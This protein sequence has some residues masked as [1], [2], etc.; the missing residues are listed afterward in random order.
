MSFAI[1]KASG[2]R[3]SE[4]PH[5]ALFLCAKTTLDPSFYRQKP[6]FAGRVSTNGLDDTNPNFKE[7]YCVISV[8]QEEGK[9]TMLF[10]R[11]GKKTS[12]KKHHRTV[13]ALDGNVSFAF[14]T[15]KGHEVELFMS[16]GSDYFVASISTQ[17]RYRV[18]GPFI[19]RP[20]E[21]Q[22]LYSMVNALIRA[23][24]RNIS[25][26][27]EDFVT[28]ES[29][30]AGMRTLLEKVEKGVQKRNVDT[31]KLNT[32]F[33]TV[34][35][36]ISTEVKYLSSYDR[37]QVS[38]RHIDLFLSC[39]ADAEVMIYETRFN[40]LMGKVEAAAS[41]ANKA[42]R[43]IASG[44]QE[45]DFLIAEDSAKVIK[46][47]GLMNMSSFVMSEVEEA[48][49]L[50][51]HEAFY[52]VKEMQK[53]HAFLDFT[54]S[55]E[56][57]NEQKK[58]NDFLSSS[59]QRVTRR[60]L[61]LGTL[62]KNLRGL[63]YF[64]SEQLDRLDE[65]LG[66]ERKRA[67]EINDKVAQAE[68]QMDVIARELRGLNINEPGRK[69]SLRLRVRS[70]L[71][72]F[73]N[74]TGVDKSVVVMM[75]VFNDCVA[76]G[77]PDANS[78]QFTLHEAYSLSGPELFHFDEQA[79]SLKVLH[80]TAGGEEFIELEK[81][82]LVGDS[83]QIVKEAIAEAEK[84]AKA[85]LLSFPLPQREPVRNSPAA[86]LLNKIGVRAPSPLGGSN[87]PP[88]PQGSYRAGSPQRAPSPGVWGMFQG[89]FRSRPPSPSKSDASHIANV[90]LSPAPTVV[91]IRM[92][93]GQ[94]P[95]K[96]GRSYT[97]SMSQPGSVSKL[98]T[99]APSPNQNLGSNVPH[100]Q[101][102]MSTPVPNK[103]SVHRAP[104]PGLRDSNSALG[105]GTPQKATM[106]DSTKAALDRHNLTT[107]RIQTLSS[108]ENRAPTS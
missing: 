77:R 64:S 4:F 52:L 91:P 18:S 16:K 73:S 6:V 80:R 19:I 100:R 17:E 75:Y 106:Y 103:E 105:R 32:L 66:T 49:L 61:L 54:A 94:T 20:M 50:K 51:T 11:A 45:I 1:R 37:F 28:E 59:M 15:L 90:P 93:R 92:D 101:M 31:A 5:P 39:F 24:P 33:R 95:S 89:S 55:L 62:C 60:P 87:R 9:G 3:V 88:S 104:S 107:P 25:K 13:F 57:A 53:N 29:V 26:L 99:R 63:N 10:M 72:N 46:L 36:A 84:Y 35:E 102:M 82:D 81:I 69:C 14:S 86:A 71:G 44:L 76:I 34:E 30:L 41:A 38:M 42:M 40:E 56:L 65:M 23:G 7:Y 12:S 108:R 70:N 78:D 58:L 96:T 2:P 43:T 74:D 67:T 21:G 47:C 68:L 79:K 8:D 22:S 85:N 97:A 27:S 48:L 98:P 83:F